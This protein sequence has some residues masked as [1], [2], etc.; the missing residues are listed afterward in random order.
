M[1]LF[2][3]M[4]ELNNQRKLNR[5]VKLK[6]ACKDGDIFVGYYSDFIS[7]FDN[8]AEWDEIEIS[9]P[10]CKRLCISEPEIESIEVIK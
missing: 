3:R 7:A 6:V 9:T 5:F 8:D 4:K 1:T 10:W 2:E